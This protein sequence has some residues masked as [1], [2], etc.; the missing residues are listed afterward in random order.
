MNL[1]VYFLKITVRHPAID[2][3]FSFLGGGTV[4]E[5]NSTQLTSCSKALEQA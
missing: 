5:Y 1:K 2:F 4:Q 3:G